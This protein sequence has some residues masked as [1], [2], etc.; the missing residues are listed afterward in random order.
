LELQEKIIAVINAN[1]NQGDYVEGEATLGL[2]FIKYVS[3]TQLI[4]PT[5]Y[6]AVIIDEEPFNFGQG[7]CATIYGS[8]Q[9]CTMYLLIECKNLDVMTEEEIKNYKDD[10]YTKTKQIIDKLIVKIRGIN[11]GRGENYMT[12]IEAN[13]CMQMIL[14][15]KAL[16]IN[17]QK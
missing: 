8:T 17:K 2:D 15:I 5:A 14:P 9:E 3:R 12:M 1:R 10:L 16:I 6:P 11:F 4:V 7:D 13:P